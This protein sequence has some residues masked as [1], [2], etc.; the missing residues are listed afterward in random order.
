MGD[1]EK[2]KNV[3]ESIVRRY[4]TR[5]WQD[6]RQECYLKFYEIGDRYHNLVYHE[7]YRVMAQSMRNTAYDYA[8]SQ[9]KASCSSLDEM[10]HNDGE[11]VVTFM[12][13]IEDPRCIMSQFEAANWLNMMRIPKRDRRI[14]E[15]YY[16]EGYT[17]TEMEEL[18]PELDLKKS[19]IYNIINKY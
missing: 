5:H 12:D 13:I 9:L 11:V 4:D 1:L 7:Y 15:L 18:H 2:F 3:I 14:L 6:L 19:Q 16:V 8:M 17:P 10:V